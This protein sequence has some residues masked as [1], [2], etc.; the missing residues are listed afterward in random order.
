MEKQRNKS[1]EERI[2]KSSKLPTLIE[3]MK[4]WDWMMIIPYLGL[5]LVL[6]IFGFTSEGRLFGSYNISIVIQ[7]TVS[8]AIVCLG[9]V[10]VYSMG[11]LDISI[12][13]TIGLCTLIQ[14]VILNATGNL[15]LGFG[16]AV[17]LALTFGLVNGAVSS[18]LGLPSVI[19]SLFLMFIGTGVQ[20]I[21]TLQTNTIRTSYDF[22][23]WKNMY[24]QIGALILMFAIVYY[25]FN[26]TR[27]G[28]YTSSI[29]ANIEFA[30][31]SGV[32]VFRNKI[33]AYLIMGFCVAIASLFILAR[34]GSSSRVTG[35]GFH[36]DVMVALILGGM[37]LSGG[38]KSKVSA[39]LIGSFTYIL[40]TNGLTLSGVAVSNV[41]LVKS[42]IFAVIV[43]I[44]SR[45]KGIV[46][47][48]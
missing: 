28:K 43:I 27:L 18:W 30:K 34:S 48:R 10:F 23:F 41:P 35:A 14:A 32:N 6:I 20:T 19:T 39:A 3:R 21:I 16:A 7:Q 5:I 37:P 44:T 9:G 2:V 29:G 26:Y 31:Q 33:Y 12:G 4:K 22:S 40:L 38:M 1:R 13:A 11:N 42:L 36:M 46:L 47:P 45:K 25:L 15:F 17:A 8:L 24:V